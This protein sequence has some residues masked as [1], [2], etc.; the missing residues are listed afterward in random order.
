MQLLSLLSSATPATPAIQARAATMPAVPM[1]GF[2]LLVEG[3]V[4]PLEP[5]TARPTTPGEA[6]PQ[7]QTSDDAA[8]AGLMQAMGLT[9]P[10]A[11][12]PP[13][14][15]TAI[16]VP[17]GDGGGEIAAAPVVP[18]GLV[19][20][21]PTAAGA[22]SPA[23]TPQTRSPVPANGPALAQGVN[24]PTPVPAV[25]TDPQ[26]AAAP[27]IISSPVA[28]APT[29]G[30]VAIAIPA[31][32]QTM[33]A[34]QAGAVAQPAVKPTAVKPTE[35]K[36]T[37]VADIAASRSAPRT[38]SAAMATTDAAPT[39]S[40][41]TTGDAKPAALRLPVGE[42]NAGGG[43]AA[44]ATIPATPPDNF[45]LP[46]TTLSSQAIG[47]DL[48]AH[49]VA[50]AR[51]TVAT[52]ATPGLQLVGRIEQAVA[53]EQTTLTVQLDPE[54]LGRVEV[55]LEMQDGRVTAMIAAEK[56]AT[57]DLLQRDVRLIERA[58]QQGGMQVQPDGLHFSLREGAG[59]W[60]QA[61]QGRRG[62]QL[63]GQQAQAD[64]AA[65][66]LAPPAI[67]RTDSLVDIQI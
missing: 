37:P 57:L 54:H 29:P 10:V 66:P 20:A 38:R 31:E 21:L 15:P 3:M 14:V 63:Y 16:A 17:V 45:T 56:P 43:E 9:T 67:I 53:Q 61:D 22:P 6:A 25:A 41:V 11:S 58:L 36:P 48:T 5:V 55:K 39:S 8:L 50:G 28:T 62:A 27:D 13:A 26:A 59:Q 23:A 52:H 44:P 4:R 24:G 34:V 47:R 35:G 51:P 42:V 49:A 60:T 2:G 18:A 40:A 1:A 30:I 32:L 65:D 64:P 33:A 7:G 46:A 12:P 19:P